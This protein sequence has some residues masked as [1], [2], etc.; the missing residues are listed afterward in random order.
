MGGLAAR[1]PVRTVTRT[2]VGGSAAAVL[3]W[4]VG[5]GG[6]LWSSSPS[7]RAFRAGSGASCQGR[8][9]RIARRWSRPGTA[10]HWPRPFTTPAMLMIEFF[11][12][13][14]RA[15]LP[16]FHTNCPDGS[17]FAQ[18]GPHFVQNTTTN[19]CSLLSRHK[20]LVGICTYVKHPQPHPK[21]PLFLA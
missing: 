16:T 4:P 1:A 14:S 19:P 17:H 15:L 18:M 6:A 5:S 21:T 13:D 10:R 9:Q 20:H 3:L 7:G 12:P 8:F 2:G 11:L